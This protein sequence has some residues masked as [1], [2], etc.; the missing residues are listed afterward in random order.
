M[1]FSVFVLLAYFSLFIELVLIPVP[2]VVST[3]QLVYKSKEQQRT[4]VLG[5]IRSFPFIIKLFR[6]ILPA[7]LNIIT[8]SLPLLFIFLPISKSL[9]KVNPMTSIGFNIAALV[10]IFIGRV[11]TLL[12]SIQL[13]KTAHPGDAPDFIAVSGIFNYS[14]NPGI[15]GML[16]FI[17]GALILFPSIYFLIGILFYTVYMHYKVLLEEKYLTER[18]AENY[19]PYKSKVPRYL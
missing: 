19:L 6:F 4:E 1:I 17:I 12:S 7:F 8:F 3:Y 11:I 15:L 14:R 10:L 13:N 5:R 2:S 18:F 9:L 16:L